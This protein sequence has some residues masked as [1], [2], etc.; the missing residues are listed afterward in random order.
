MHI[1]NSVLRAGD[2][3]TCLPHGEQGSGLAT[4]NWLNFWL[5]V[6]Y[7]HFKLGYL[8]ATIS[9]P[10]SWWA[11]VCSVWCR[12]SFCFRRL[13]YLSSKYELHTLLNELHESASQR[14]VPHRDFYN[15]RKV[16]VI[17][18]FV[19]DCICLCA[20]VHFC[21]K[22]SCVYNILLQKKTKLIP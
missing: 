5:A 21:V 20:A 13:N 15:V 3:Q 9:H 17:Y 14:Q 8:L 16:S 11:L 4:L 6:T 7:L 2:C 19:Y 1:I 12:K 18:F 10:S 22:T